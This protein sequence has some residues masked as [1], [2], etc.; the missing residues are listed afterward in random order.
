M[1]AINPES[2]LFVCDHPESYLFV[3]DHP[4]SYHMR[5]ILCAPSSGAIIVCA[6]ILCE[7]ASCARDQSM[8]ERFL[9]PIILCENV[10][11][12]PGYSPPVQQLTKRNLQKSHQFAT[13]SNC[14][15]NTR[16]HHPLIHAERFCLLVC[17]VLFCCCCLLV[18]LL[19]CLVT[20]PSPFFS[21]PIFPPL[22]HRLTG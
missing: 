1:C 6:I 11:C 15:I 19:V 20:L 10:S 7:S 21:R 2:Y 16:T 17:F 13:D 18:D 4:G 22:Q 5:I 9:C 14:T 8:L 3:C 12:L